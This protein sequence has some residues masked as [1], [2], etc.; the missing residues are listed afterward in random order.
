MN[1]LLFLLL[2][3]SGLSVDAQ[4]FSNYP[5]TLP[6]VGRSSLAW[7]DYDN[8]GDLDLFISGSMNDETRIASVYRN[9]E[10]DFMDIMAGLEGIKE[11]ASAWGDYDDDGD[12]DLIVC[13]NT[14]SGD[15]TLL[16]N[17][18]SGVF[19]LMETDFVGVSNGDIAWSDYDN[20]GDLDIFITGNWMTKV[21]NNEGGVF[22]EATSNFGFWDSSSIAFGD[23]DNDGDADLLMIGDSGSGAGTKVYKNKDG[24][25]TAIDYIF[26]GLLAGTTDWV[27]FDSDGDLDIA[28]SGYNDAIEAQYHMFTNEGKDDFTIFYSGI[29]GMGLSS[30]DWGDYDNDGDLDVICTGK[31]TGCGAATSGIYTN[32][33]P[34]FTRT[35]DVFTT[36]LRGMITW[37][38]FENDGDLDFAVTGADL[39]DSAFT[40]IYRND[41]GDNTFAMNTLP[42]V[43]ENLQVIIEE[44]EAILSWNRA[45][46]GQTSQESLSYNLYVGI[47]PLGSEVLSPLSDPV[48]GFRKVV[49]IGN[50]SEDT[51]LRISGL[52]EGAYFWSVQAVDQ[53]FSASPF[54]PEQTFTITLTGLPD[55]GTENDFRVYPNPFL[56][57]VALQSAHTIQR[58]EIFS[59]DGKMV[60]RSET[61]PTESVIS[62]PGL[63]SGIY[64]LRAYSEDTQPSAVRLFK[65]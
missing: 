43:P 7:A 20:D 17:N 12:Y 29:D 61:L 24:V 18:D 34:F 14:A 58:I 63:S 51:T 16:Y 5:V 2:I 62:L 9:D 40:K 21:Y 23:Y 55:T 33:Y 35:A 30:S 47:S 46:D 49:Q 15:K 57:E 65:R 42:A 32:E 37:V 36:A 19:Y 52:N 13:G 31:A 48:T 10:G 54:A 53:L 44:D 3:L 1:K 22:E 56:N 50:A 4:I 45:T 64:I 25:F 60:Y 41:G 59:S 39:G 11:S 28:I 38:D 27:D 6:D 8:D 26:P